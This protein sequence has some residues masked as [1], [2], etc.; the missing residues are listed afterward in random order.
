M[1]YTPRLTQPPVSDKRWIN[2]R[3]GGYNSCIVRDSSNGNV[4]P[5][6]TGYVHGRWMEI[7]NTNSEYNLSLGN[8]DTYWGHNDGYQ[9]STTT[10]QLG[11]VVCFD[12]SGAGHVAIVEE[13]IDADTIVCSES[14]YSHEYFIT[15]TRYRRYGWNPSASSAWGTT[16]QGFIYHPD[17]QGG[18]PAPSEPEPEPTVYNLTVTGGT[19]DKASGEENKTVKVTATVGNGEIFKRWNLEGGGSIDNSTL[20][21]VTYTFSGSDGHLIAVTAKVPGFIYPTVIPVYHRNK[22]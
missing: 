1:A 15:R 4:L 17:N 10:P 14:N 16:F 6:C 20:R 9:R 11:A 19:P 3:Y 18:G 22:Y 8:A 2:T 21:T 5:N 12:S 13:I 7:G